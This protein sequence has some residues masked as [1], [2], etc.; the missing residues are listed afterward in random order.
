MNT[1]IAQQLF[2]RGAFFVLLD[3]APGGEIGIDWVNW[4]TDE[5]FKGIKLIPP[6]IHYIYYRYDK[7]GRSRYLVG[8]W[9]CSRIGTYSG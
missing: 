9:K 2:E 1:Q 8:N 6:G 4:T 7:T 3:F 5:K